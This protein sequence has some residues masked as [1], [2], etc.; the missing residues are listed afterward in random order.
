MIR[1]R[2]FITLLGGAAWPLAARAQQG[3]RVRRIGVLG[4]NYE[5]DPRVMSVVSAL[6]QALAGLGWTDGRNV[7][8]DLRWYGEDINRAR[9]LAQELVGL[10]PDI[11]VTLGAPAVLA[12]QRETRTIPIVF[13]G[14]AD[15]VAY[16]VVGRLAADL[17]RRRPAV[18]VVS[19]TVGSAAAAKAADGKIPVVFTM[20]SDPAQLGIVTSFSRPGANITGSFNFNEMLAGKMVG[21]LHDLV[22]SAKTFSILQSTGAFDFMLDGQLSS[23]REAA[24]ALGLRLLVF[25]AGTD[26]EIEAAFAHMVEQ[27]VQALLVPAEADFLVRA[28]EIAGLAA[29]YGLPAMYG[30][31]NY[32]A[33][34]GLIS[35]GDN[36]AEG[37]RQVGIYAGRILKGEKPADLPVV[38]TTRLEL[39]INLKTAKALGL[40]VPTNLLSLADEVIEQ[41]QRST[42][43]RV[44]RPPG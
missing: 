42:S 7:R 17:V 33:A 8:M 2:D 28:Q 1:R 3:D 9:A 19:T 22:P 41:V 40:D 5:N 27:Q 32:V 12:L 13:A 36:V 14:V 20:G 6:T 39:V 16:G 18:I 30:R 4:R 35:Y 31:R 15:P 11:I 44:V 38:Q 21:L 34:G 25:R 29:R 43:F 26:S 23:A 24:D 10:Q 37:F